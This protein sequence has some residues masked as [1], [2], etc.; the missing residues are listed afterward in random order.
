MDDLNRI[1]AVEAGKLIAQKELSAVELV[2]NSI[3]QI[4]ELDDTLNSF[5]LRFDDQALKKAKL[6]DDEL[7]DSGPRGPL[8][9]VPIA[10]KDLCDMQGVPTYA[11]LPNR[12]Q[13]SASVDA[14]VADR[15]KAAG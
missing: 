6:L 4:N 7:K 5:I 11:G 8:H 1:G 12:A 10:V 3:S 13:A 14:S 9:G 15:L 2:S